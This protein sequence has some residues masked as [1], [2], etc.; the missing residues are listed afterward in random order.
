[1]SLTKATYSMISGACINVLDY[2]AVGDGTTNDTTAIQAAI[3]AALAGCGVVYFPKGTY[4]YTSAT[5]FLIDPFTAQKSLTLIGDGP[6]NTVFNLN[7]NNKIFTVNS[8]ENGSGPSFMFNVKGISFSLVTPATNSAA[9]CFYVCRTAND[10]G[11][12]F[13]FEDCYFNNFSYAAVWGVRCFNSGA[14]RTIFHGASVYHNGS[15]SNPT[16]FDDACVRLWGADGTLTLQ[17]HS[18]SNE[19]RFEQ[20]HFRDT[21]IGFDGWNVVGSFNECTF[22][23]VCYGLIVRP[24][25]TSGVYGNVSSLEKGGYGLCQVSVRT[26]WFEDIPQ[27]AYANVDLNFV[28]AALINPSIRAVFNI[29]IQDTYIANCA[30]LTAVGVQTNLSVTGNFDAA[31][32][33][34][35]LGQVSCATATWVPIFQPSPACVYILIVRIFNVASAQTSATATLFN[36]FFDLTML[37]KAVG[38]AIDLRVTYPNIEVQQTTGS[39]QLVDYSVIR[40]L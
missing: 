13:Y 25:P 27:Y 39:T 36:S 1:M 24:N 15:V 3:T 34:T 17:D 16:G 5:T 22:T 12:H 23:E 7:A 10:W 11:A 19:A 38:S 29:T 2:G 26:C 35:S 6:Q 31:L 40:M 28:T 8:G 9:T 14:K 32:M 4:A 30:S 18:F 33:S 21:R 20:C 37:N